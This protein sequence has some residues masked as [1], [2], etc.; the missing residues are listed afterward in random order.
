M[1]FGFKKV[2]IFVFWLVG[3]NGF[4]LLLYFYGRNVVF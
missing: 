3:F 4:A 2:W 1:I